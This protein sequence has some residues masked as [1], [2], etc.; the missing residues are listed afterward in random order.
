MK[1]WMIWILSLAGLGAAGWFF[2]RGDEPA[3]PGQPSAKYLVCPRCGL[4]VSYSKDLEGKQCPQCGKQGP[5]LRAS[6]TAGGARAAVPPAG[7]RLAGFIVGLV[8]LQV[9]AYVV[10]TRVRAS[11]QAAQARLR[12][13]LVCRCPYCNR[14]IRFPVRLAGQG[15]VCPRCRTGFV[16]PATSSPDEEDD[17]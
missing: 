4:E 3:K 12:A 2:F 13:G 7:K 14:K 11:R 6:Q 5:P 8:A 15:F 9:F 16:L 17:D 10:I 1:G